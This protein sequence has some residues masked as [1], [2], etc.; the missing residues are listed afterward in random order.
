M[1]EGAAPSQ[2]RQIRDDNHDKE[3]ELR[4]DMINAESHFNFVKMHLLNVG[5]KQP[6]ANWA[7]LR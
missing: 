4:M 7:K 6:I 5:L 1:R 2:R 3:N